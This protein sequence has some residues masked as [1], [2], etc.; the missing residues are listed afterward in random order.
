MSTTKNMINKLRK[1]KSGINKIADEV[2]KEIAEYAKD[3]IEKNYQSSQLQEGNED[4]KTEI[5]KDGTMYIVKTTGSQILYTEFG[6][7][8][9]GASH[10]HPEK[11]SF[12]LNDYNS[13]ET[14]R[15]NSNKDTNASAAGIPVG[16]LYWTYKDKNGDKVYTQGIPAGMQIY[17]AELSTRRKAKS[18]AKRKVADVLSKL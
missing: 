17:R 18:I 15:P 6:T 9:K 2:G 10:P 7:G 12:A 14:I 4:R 1:L 3:Q 16:G 13:G 5:S 11:G 8:T